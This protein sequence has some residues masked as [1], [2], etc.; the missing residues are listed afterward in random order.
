MGGGGLGF[1]PQ[2]GRVEELLV[3]RGLSWHRTLPRVPSVEVGHAV[4]HVHK[5]KGLVIRFDYK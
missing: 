4:S 3:C 5:G 1:S 2:R